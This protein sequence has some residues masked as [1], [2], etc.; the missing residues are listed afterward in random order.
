MSTTAASSSRSSRRASGATAP[1]GWPTDSPWRRAA[2][3]A[4][5]RPSG[6]FRMSGSA[7]SRGRPSTTSR[8]GAAISPCCARRLPRWRKG[9]GRCRASATSGP[10]R[11]PP[12]RRSTWSS[13]A[14]PRTACASGFPTSARRSTTPSPSGRSRPSTASATST[15]SCSPPSRGRGR[16]RTRLPRTGGRCGAAVPLGVPPAGRRR[17]GAEDQDD[18]QVRRV[19]PV[20]VSSTGFCRSGSPP[21][22]PSRSRRPSPSRRS[23]GWRCPRRPPA[24]SRAGA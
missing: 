6:R 11:T 23:A 7:R 5:R 2:S 18:R 1:G 15:G 17:P 14:R 4:S 19:R 10:T 12:R 3:R 20:T 21:S 8:S 9:S 24:T 16:A 22:R 13:T